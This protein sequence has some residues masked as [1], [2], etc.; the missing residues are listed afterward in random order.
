MV[1]RS[2]AISSAI[3]TVL[4]KIEDAVDVKAYQAASEDDDGIRY[5]MDEVIQIVLGASN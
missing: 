2:I 4:E 3:E 1:M 5:T